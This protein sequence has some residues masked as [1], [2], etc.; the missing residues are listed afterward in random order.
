MKVE[1]ELSELES[2]RSELRKTLEQNQKLEAAYNALS[3]KELKRN[4]VKL[5]YLLFNNY[6]EAVFKKLGFGDWVR[7]SVFF[8]DD[9]EHYLGKEWWQNER[10][11]VDIQIS[12]S[13]KFKSAFLQL[14][15]IPKEKDTE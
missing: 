7:D 1:V 14:G 2:L 13:E 3:E 11:S 6:M 5:S 15:V 10:L 9:L 12:V 4:A 8:R